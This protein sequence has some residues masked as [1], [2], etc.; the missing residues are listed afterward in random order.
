[1]ARAKADRFAFG[2]DLMP[3]EEALALLAAKL[4]PVTGTE[5]VSLREGLNRTLAEAVIAPRH[6]PPHDNAA[7]D[8]YA[9]FFDDLSDAERLLIEEYLARHPQD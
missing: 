8:G 4:R 7:V 2:G 9:V 3:V 6:V 1:M 5:T